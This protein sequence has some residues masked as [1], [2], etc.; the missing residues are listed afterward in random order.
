VAEAAQRAAERIA[1]VA[2]DRATSYGDLDRRGTRMA[3]LLRD[4]GCV[5]GDR[6]GL[7]VPK[8][9]A[10]IVGMIGALRAGCLYVPLD[11]MSP[12]ARLARILAA[13][14]PR[15]V[16][17]EGAGAAAAAALADRDEARGARFGRLDRG[18][19]GPFRFDGGD[20][21]SA[22][23]Q[24]LPSAASAD[25]A[26]HILFTSGSTGE[27]KGVVVTHRSVLAFVE[28]ANGYF[29]ATA[30]DRNSGHSPF[31]FDLSTYDI[32][33]TFA[34]GAELH[35]VDPAWN[36]LPHR[37]AAFIR[38]RRLTQ[39]FSVPSVLSYMAKLD[40]L[41]QDDLPD[42]RRVLWCGEVFPTPSLIYW[43]KRLP[44][45]RFTNLYGPTEAT[46]ASSYH[47]LERPPEDP[48]AE[49]PIGRACAGETLHVLDGAL[50]P[51][52]PGSPGDLY[53]GG[54][55][56]SPGYWEQPELTAQAFVD[57]P[58]RGRL[59]RTGDRARLGRDGLVYFLG[60]SDQQIKSRGYRIELGEIE[61]ALG[62]LPDLRESAVVAIPTDGFEGHR[63]CCA[64][65]LRPGATAAPAAVRRQLAALLPP[66]ML[67][68]AWRRVPEL[69]RTPNGKVDRR[70][71]R[72]IFLADARPSPEGRSA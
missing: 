9:T 38:E 68:A 37:L 3:H 7:L 36:L 11:L 19:G 4:Q 35:L 53:L 29:G 49:V 14:R 72:S 1:V 57:A 61:Q 26:A 63:I 44:R 17:C 51:A 27:P 16:L 40:V 52:A 6:V 8:S 13:C 54:V 60:R 43:M 67:P 66:Y 31:F 48:A 50:R 46:I 12:P 42:L 30:G 45:A 64:Y 59:Y 34:A 28:W 22:P 2:G 25:G 56:L 5:P 39:W 21:E 10:G 23:E 70:A 32:Y 33:G 69:P 62:T 41:R 20:L 55:G 24:A 47:T 15:V 18:G 65:A 71:I 58:G